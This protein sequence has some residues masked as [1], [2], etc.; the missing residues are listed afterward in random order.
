MSKRTQHRS[1]HEALTKALFEATEDDLAAD[2]REEGLD[3]DAVAGEMRSL[4]SKTVKDFKQKA[5]RAAKEQ[6]REKAAALADVRFQ[7][8]PSAAERRQLLDAVISQHQQAG[9]MLIAQHRDFTALSDEDVDSWLQQFGALGLLDAKP[10][11]K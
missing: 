11:S 10:D 4:L 9:R 6:H 8:P 1:L 2:V 7:L 3:P 5:L